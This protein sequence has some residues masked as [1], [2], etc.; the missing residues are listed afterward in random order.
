MNG[1]VTASWL[2]IRQGPGTEYKIVGGL[3]EGTPVSWTVA[4]NGWL[5]IGREEWVHGDWVKI[6]QKP[7]DTVN[8]SIIRPVNAPISQL[9]GDRHDYYFK[10]FRIPGHNGTDYA[11]PQGTPL[12]AIADGK[13]RTVST[14]PTG[15][16]N[17][18]EVYHPALRLY[19]LY[20]HLHRTDVVSGQF[21]QQG[22]RVGLMGSTGNSTGPHL[23]FE[24]RLA[25]L[26]DEPKHQEWPYYEQPL[27]AGHGRGR[28]NPETVFALLDRL[29]A[30][31]EVPL[32][33]MVPENITTP[34]MMEEIL[35]DHYFP[36]E[37]TTQP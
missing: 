24:I 14:D 6:E 26:D 22:D 36:A 18:V 25:K 35:K 27:H 31:N 20:A 30:H 9:F 13:V 3:E 33:E 10:T 28:I 15:Y 2:N 19:S 29:P 23:H 1:V 7:P 17:W 16:G 5:N 8:T 32:G 12:V 21:V 4:E 34:E 11:A 37:G